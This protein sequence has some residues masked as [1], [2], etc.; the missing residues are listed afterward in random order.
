M[1]IANITEAK[2]HLSELV[3]QALAGND[4]IIAK[5]D[6]LLVKLTPVEQDISPRR[7][8]FWAGQVQLH[9]SWENMDKE[10]EALFER[11]LV[12]SD[13]AS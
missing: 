5:G 3:R 13:D 2:A 1:H 8:G 12:E 7:G 10:I 6:Q 4:V 9:D 11:S